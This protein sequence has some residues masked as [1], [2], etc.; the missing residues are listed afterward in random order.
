MYLK[1]PDL[2]VDLA[3]LDDQQ[4]EELK[5]LVRDEVARRTPAPDIVFD[6]AE[7]SMA[8]CGLHVALVR[9]VRDRLERETGFKPSL[10]SAVA[11]AKALRLELFPHYTAG[12]TWSDATMSWAK[13]LW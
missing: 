13:D 7:K 2:Y 9:H 1:C 12:M 11:A 4:L 6:E 10:A 5:H 3:L 8:R